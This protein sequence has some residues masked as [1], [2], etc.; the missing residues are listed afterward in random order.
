MAR[1]HKLA[2][3]DMTELIERIREGGATPVLVSPTMFDSRAAKLRMNP[4]RP[5]S[6]EMLSQYNSVLAYYGRWLQDV[7]I[8]TGT[9]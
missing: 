3:M 9:S 4:R 2:E 1:K 5:R 8:E 7:A 6:T